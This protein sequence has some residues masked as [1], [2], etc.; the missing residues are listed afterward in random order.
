MFDASPLFFC[1]SEGPTIAT[2][3]E[4][5]GAGALWTNKSGIRLI[6]GG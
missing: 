4:D 3:L 2:H 5:R 6:N 1:H